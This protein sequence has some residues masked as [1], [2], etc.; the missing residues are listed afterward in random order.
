M[1]NVRQKLRTPQ[2]PIAPAPGTIWVEFYKR[3]GEWRPVPKRSITIAEYLSNI[4]KEAT[5]WRQVPLQKGKKTV[6]DS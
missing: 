5:R 3:D 2:P 6:I 1:P 4:S